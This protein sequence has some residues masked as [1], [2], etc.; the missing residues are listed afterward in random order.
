MNWNAVSAIGQAVSALALILVF[1]QVRDAREEM[2]IATNRARLEGTRDMFLA[3]ATNAELGDAWARAQIVASGQPPGPYI[4]Y[5]KGLGLSDVDAY[6][7]NAYQWAVW[8]HFQ[9]TIMTRD[10]L[11]PGVKAEF[12]NRV[13]GQFHDSVGGKWY[14]LAKPGLNPDA[15]GYIDTVLARPAS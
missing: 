2:E 6:L 15:V 12:E 1:V 3:Q 11:S 10:R 13:R 9:I 7:V 5:L 8:N 4:Q 14:E